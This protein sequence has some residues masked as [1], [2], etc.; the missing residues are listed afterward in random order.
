MNHLKPVVRYDGIE[1]GSPE[2]RDQRLARMRKDYGFVNRNGTEYKTFADMETILQPNAQSEENSK[3]SDFITAKLINQDQRINYLFMKE[4]KHKP[5]DTLGQRNKKPVLK[6]SFQSLFK[7]SYNCSS[8][9]NIIWS[10]KPISKE[11]N[12]NNPSINYDP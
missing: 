10:E 2:R 5:T 6:Q 12:F 7:T 1:S 3:F 11:L 9:S 8:E 4:G